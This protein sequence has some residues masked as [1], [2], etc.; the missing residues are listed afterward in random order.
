MFFYCVTFVSRFHTKRS[1]DNSIN[2][3]DNYIHSSILSKSKILKSH[4]FK[5]NSNIKVFK[6]F[7]LI[8]EKVAQFE[9]DSKKFKLIY[10]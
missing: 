4:L 8:F 3:F 7:E 1:I 9:F 5:N 2:I 10:S 6:N